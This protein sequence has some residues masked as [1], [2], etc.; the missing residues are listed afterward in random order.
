MSK[1]FFIDLTKCTA[2]RGCQVACKQWHKLPAEETKNWGSHQNPKDT[3][4]NTYKLVR[5]EEVEVNGELKWLFFP[6]QCRHCVQPPCQQSADDPTAILQDETTGAVIFTAKTAKEDIETIRG[7]CPYDVP[8]Q[9]PA[10]KIMAKCDMCLDRVHNGMLP[11]C[12]QI[13]PT[14]AM[15]FGELED[16]QAMAKERLAKVKKSKPKAMLVDPD[17]VRVIYLTEYDPKLYYK[18]IMA[19]ASTRNGVMTRQEMLARMFRPVKR[20]FS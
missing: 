14:G 3:S 11:A 20:T 17:D 7:A 4:F 13:C 8:R 1:G 15:N 12:V 16:M 10:S 2:C 9:D 5:F 19:D 6:E 18:A